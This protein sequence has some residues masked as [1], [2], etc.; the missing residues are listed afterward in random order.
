MYHILL[1]E[2]EKIERETLAKI[3]EQ[4][5]LDVDV[6]C[7]KNGIEALQ[8]AQQTQ[9]DLVCAD[10]NMPKLNGL[11]MIREMRTVQEDACYLILTSYNYF[12]YAQE[13]IRLGVSDFMLKPYNIKEFVNV[14]DHHLKSKGNEHKIEKQ[15]I[16]MMEKDCLFSILANVSEID[17]YQYVKRL[18]KHI[19]SGFCFLLCNCTTKNEDVQRICKNIKDY[20]YR[21]L[22]E[23]VH[24][25]TICFVL[26]NKHFEEE[27][28]ELI[29]KCLDT[30]PY[31]QDVSAGPIVNEIAQ[32]HHS[33][34]IARNHIGSSIPLRDQLQLQQSQTYDTSTIASMCEEVCLCFDALDEDALKQQVQIIT[35]RFIEYDKKQILKYVNEFYDILL[36]EVHL[37]Y[38]DIAIQKFSLLPFHVQD[39]IYQDLPLNLL[40]NFKKILHLIDDIRY[41]NTNHFVKEAITYIN[42]NY[43]KQI[44]LAD[45]ADHLNISPYYISKLLSA[46]LHKSFTELVSEKRVEESK[47]LLR[48]NEPI[49][50]IAGKVGFQGQSYFNKIFKKY[51]GVT[52]K[53]YRLR[54]K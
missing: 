35:E 18:D 51:T 30:F 3:I 10:I 42:Q 37:R 12:E 26:S 41:R 17:L 54:M 14:I 13:A 39:S 33:L 23:H 50:A 34:Q 44:V 19:C 2:D 29:V 27:K 40:L 11:D 45:L 48:S 53:V 20:G 6:D 32:F 9:Y 15:V 43:A 4:E 31:P 21:I 24:N 38:P 1:V 46:S 25:T 36:K 5:I 16:S 7:A 8:K 22:C 49:K 28:L 47:K 52:P